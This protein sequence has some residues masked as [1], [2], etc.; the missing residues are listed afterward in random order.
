LFVSSVTA[1][2]LASALPMMLA[3]VFK[4][5][6]DSAIRLPTNDVVVPSVAELPI[7]QATLHGFPPLIRATVDPLAVVNVVPVL[8]MKIA[9]A[10]PCALSVSVPV[11]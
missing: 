7:C 6:L 8:K 4:A 5:I 11:N 10:L 1:P 9:F 2:F 3:P